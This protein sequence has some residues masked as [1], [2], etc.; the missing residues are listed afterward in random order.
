MA[1]MRE[2]T[3]PLGLAVLMLGAVLASRARADDAV[4]PG[5]PEKV[6]HWTTKNGETCDDVATAL[7]GAAKHRALL[8][9]YNSVSC[10]AGR[11]LPD[12]MT[13]VVPAKVTDLPSAHLRSLHP[14]VKARPPGGAWQPA[15]S[16]MSLYRNHSVNT[17]EKARA[18]I[19][20]I[21]RTRVVLAEHTLVII[22]GTARNTAVSKTPPTVELDSGELQAGLAALRGKPLDVAT[23]GGRVTA[24]SRDT[25]VRAKNKRATVSVFDGSAS[26]ASANKK[27]E[28]PTNHGTAFVENRAPEPPRP[29]PPGPKWLAST[30]SGTLLAPPGASLIAAGWEGVAKARIYRVELAKDAGFTE[31]LAREEVPADVHAFRA[32]RL[33][34]GSYFMR[35]RAV[36]EDDFLGI[37]SEVKNVVLAEARVEGSRA[38]ITGNVI[39]LSPYGQL[40]LAGFEGLELAIDDGA[41]GKIPGSIDLLRLAPKSIRLR[42][43]GSPAASTYSL[44]YK[45]PRVTAQASF[46]TEA[47]VVRVRARIDDARGVDVAKRMAPAARI[48]TGGSVKRM[49]LR[50]DGGDWVAEL[51]G[52][53]ESPAAVQIVDV[54]GKVLAEA[55]ARRPEVEAPKA[56]AP[57]R[58]TP[59]PSAPLV[60]PSPFSNVTPWAPIPADSAAIGVTTYVEDGHTGALL[61]A[62]ASGSLGS[63]GFDGLVASREL[64]GP[65]ADGSG[66]LRLR[67]RPMQKRDFELG[68]AAE[69]GFPLSRTSA[70]T[71]VGLGLG[72]GGFL[73]ELDY[74]ANIGGRA[75]VASSGGRIV[76][77]D[78]QAYLLGSLGYRV[79]PWL[80][81]YAS[82]DAHAALDPADDAWVMRGGLTLGAEIGNELF[83][84][85]ALRASAW[86]EDGGWLMG[87]LTLGLRAR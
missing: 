1:A 79:A 72:A 25:A 62:R 61:A 15:Q 73:G 4:T 80:H 43:R 87:Q 27:V 22:Y 47:S 35:V 28:V 82:L 68:P 54:R 32:E 65:P 64:D 21:D 19:L 48:A 10:Q 2:R 63:F 44:A 7:Y 13:L 69:V 55:V 76:T 78:A 16:G 45:E 9:R 77:P 37:S 26:V 84:G 29:L 8:E 40:S 31:L 71:R 59:G 83:G 58:R 20:F 38:E 49:A 33:P 23:Q 75:P 51:A 67:W 39:E 41:F 24:K 66:F 3:L 14:D 11:K 17:L 34:P 56:A 12:G 46:D 74:L 60:Q 86:D 6:L 53:S 50:A 18:D 70:P 5:Y 36:D 30:S 85:L 52:V 81:P 57:P 42:M